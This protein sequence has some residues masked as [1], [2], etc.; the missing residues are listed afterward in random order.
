MSGPQSGIY[1]LPGTLKAV[2]ELLV[3]TAI[4]SRIDLNPV[5]KGKL[6]WLRV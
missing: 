4:T 1:L 3:T 5:I 6:P 2:T